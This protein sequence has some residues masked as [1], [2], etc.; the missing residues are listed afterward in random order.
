M[1]EEL[2][3]RKLSE[4]EVT[5]DGRDEDE[6]DSTEQPV[7][8]PSKE[9][10]KSSIITRVVSGLCIFFLFLFIVYMGH[11]PVF[12]LI[13]FIQAVEKEIPN[14]RT[15]HWLIFVTALFIVFGKD[16]AVGLMHYI[17]QTELI[18]RYHSL[19]SVILY[20]LDFVFIVLSLKKGYLKYQ[21]GQIAWTMLTI[22]IVVFQIRAI[23]PVIMDGLVW[24]V[25]PCLTVAWNDTMA[26]VCGLK[27]GRKFIDKPLTPLSPNKSWEG[28]IGGGLCTIVIGWIMV[29]MMKIPHLY[30]PFNQP[31]CPV[32]SYY[33]SHF[34][35]FPEWLAAAI[36]VPGVMIQPIYIHEF[37]MALFASLVAPFG[38]FFASAIKRAYGKKDFTS[39][40]PG[41]GGLMDRFDCQFLMLYFTGVYYNTFIKEKTATVVDVL[42]M[43]AD[44]TLSEKEVVLKALQDSIALK[45]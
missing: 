37:F 45:L 23:V 14:F 4:E 31:T 36:H 40:I 29:Y 21:I 42:R 30:C 43:I 34:Y 28:F 25:L 41:H 39:L 1:E 8:Q 22:I 9:K 3:H 7:S 33:V 19:I 2:R 18:V 5:A 16:A 35:A 17:P 26:Y 44:L 32:P 12:L 11:L 10:K 24:F 38:G 15:L 20:S 6:I 27:W 13:T